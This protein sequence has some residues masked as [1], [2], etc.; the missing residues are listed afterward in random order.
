METARSLY[1]HLGFTDI[2]AYYNNPL[3]EVVYLELSL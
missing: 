3:D 1:R 2:P